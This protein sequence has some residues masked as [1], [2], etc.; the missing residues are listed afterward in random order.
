[1]QR[2]FIDRTG[3]TYPLL[4]H[5]SNVGRLYGLGKTSY[6]IIDHDGVVRYITNLP[7]APPIM[8]QA[9]SESLKALAD[10][11][12]AGEGSETSVGER[13][14]RPESFALSANYPNPFNAE[15]IIGFR[16]GVETDVAIRIFDAAGRAVRLLTAGRFNPGGFELTWDGRDDGGRAVSSGVYFYHLSAPGHRATR[17][18]VL[19]R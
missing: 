9:I 16:L 4:L 2:Q 3:T 18:M 14:S 6:V 1:M 8:R 12:N 10:S 19:L 7:F 11:Q 17:S 13:E 15:T 5:A